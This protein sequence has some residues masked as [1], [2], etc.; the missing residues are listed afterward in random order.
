MFDLPGVVVAQPVGEFDLLQGVLVEPVLVAGLPALLM[1]FAFPMA[2]AIIQRAE[3]SVGRR[4]GVL[5]LANTFGAVC[6]S[7]ATGFLL[8][9]TL[10]IQRSADVLMVA[11]GMAALAIGGF[12]APNKAR[13]PRSISRRAADPGARSGARRRPIRE[14]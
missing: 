13:P 14:R 4:A 1:G 7:L 6:G 9:P 2:N 5:Y 11:A 8:L 12:G 10:G 3:A